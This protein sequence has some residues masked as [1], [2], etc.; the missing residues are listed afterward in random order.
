MSLHVQPGRDLAHRY[1]DGR[2]GTAGRPRLLADLAAGAVSGVLATA[3]MTAAMFAMHRALPRRERYAPPPWLIARQLVRRTGAEEVATPE[4]VSAF[5]WFSHFAYGGALGA[6]YAPLARRLPLPRRF[7]APAYAL[8]LWAAGY[9]GWLPAA[10]ILT[11]ATE[12]PARRNA[13]MIAAHL[14]WAAA[15]GAALAALGRTRDSRR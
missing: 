14:V 15:C 12:H 8:A 9:L 2:A 5:G 7:S 1:P 4:Q 6:A 11:P 3:P 10:R 13:L